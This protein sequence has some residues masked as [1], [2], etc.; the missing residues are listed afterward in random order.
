MAGDSEV[1]IRIWRL[2]GIASET[3]FT[4][5][6]LALKWSGKGYNDDVTDK[7]LTLSHFF[8]AFIC[9]L[10]ARMISLRVC[11]WDRNLRPRVTRAAMFAIFWKAGW[12]NAWSSCIIGENQSRIK[13]HAWLHYLIHFSQPCKRSLLEEGMFEMVIDICLLKVSLEDLCT[14]G[15]H[16]LWKHWIEVIKLRPFV[17]GPL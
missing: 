5:D 10:N 13:I 17:I 11:F 8:R 14:T 12:S 2:P 4:T 16:V 15:F 6:N 3:D 1:H 9:S 7:E